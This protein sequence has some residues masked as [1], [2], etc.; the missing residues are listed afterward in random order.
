MALELHPGEQV[1]YD[2]HPSWRSVMA[3][4]L[5]GAVA[6]LVARR[7]PL[8][9]RRPRLGRSS[10]SWS[11]V[12]HRR[13]RR[14]RPARLRALHDHRPAAA[15][16]ARHHLAARPADPHRPRPERQHPPAPDRPHAARRRRRL[17]HRRHRRLRLHLRGRQRPDRRRRRGRPGP[18]PRRRV[19]PWRPAS[20][21][22]LAGAGARPATRRAEAGGDADAHQNAPAARS[23]LPGGRS[24]MSSRSA[25]PTAPASAR[26][27]ATGRLPA[28]LVGRRSARQ[29]TWRGAVAAEPPCARGLVPA[30]SPAGA[31][32]RGCMTAARQ[33]CSGASHRPR[34]AGWP[35]APRDPRP[36]R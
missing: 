5:Q 33:G 9:R 28:S 30:L 14:L 23:V 15:H 11:C 21:G 27:A 13:A 16:P 32:D 10:R 3:L 1:I 26:C 8:V 2:G 29:P 22:S 25:V 19:A 34:A 4:Y 20:R 24:W 36:S 31:R 7:D 12:G 6:G 17:R 18:A 35:Q